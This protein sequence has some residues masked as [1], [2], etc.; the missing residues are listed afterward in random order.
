MLKLEDSLWQVAIA[1]TAP[2]VYFSTL[3]TDMQFESRTAV[4]FALTC[5][6]IS[7]MHLAY[8]FGSC[9]SSFSFWQKTQ[10][11]LR[12]QLKASSQ[13]HLF[14]LRATLLLKMVS[15]FQ[16]LIGITSQILHPPVWRS[17]LVNGRSKCFVL[18]GNESRQR[19]PEW[20]VAAVELIVEGAMRLRVGM[21]S[22]TA[23]YGNACLCVHND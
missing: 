5:C 16:R 1:F 6:F 8:C 7:C 13:L 15:C 22:N 3:Y 17:A 4:C 19:H 10:S 20:P 9:Q 18:D 2:F 21:S 11:S 12:L 23:C 14:L